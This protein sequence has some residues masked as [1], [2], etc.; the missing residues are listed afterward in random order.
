MAVLAAGTKLGPSETAGIIGALRSS[1]QA[2]EMGAASHARNTRLDRADAAKTLPDR[3]AA[4]TGG[5]SR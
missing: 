2:G 5:K 3:C 4:L 1:G